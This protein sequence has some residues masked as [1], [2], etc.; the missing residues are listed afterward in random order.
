MIDH[1][2]ARENYEIAKKLLDAAALRQEAIATNLANLETP[3][4]KRIDLAPDFAQQLARLSGNPGSTSAD[5][6]QP[7][8]AEDRLTQSLRP[9]GN[10][11][12][13]DRE[14]LEMNRNAVE[15]EFLTQYASDSIRRL[16]TAITGRV[17]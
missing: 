6:L 5:S 17:Q 10:N 11:V 13:L 15:Y 12:S 2:L 3:G 14:L 16:K 1:I 9:D 4:F 8:L 7:K